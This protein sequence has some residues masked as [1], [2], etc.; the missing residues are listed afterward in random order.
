MYEYFVSFVYNHGCDRGHACTS[1]TRQ[2]PVVTHADIQDIS[3]LIKRDN[4]YDSVV[5][6]DWRRYEE[7][8][9]PKT[10]EEY[11]EAL[12]NHIRGLDITLPEAALLKSYIDEC[13]IAFS[14]RQ[15]P[16]TVAQV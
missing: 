3:E 12:R 6:L 8:P 2:K 5:L 16:D 10:R 1:I 15:N 7:P 14:G 11:V 13:T 4:N 9:P